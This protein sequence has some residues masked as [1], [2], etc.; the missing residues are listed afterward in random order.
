MPYMV[1]ICVDYIVLRAAKLIRKSPDV[2]VVKYQSPPASRGKETKKLWPLITKIVLELIILVISEL[3][4]D[5]YH[6]GLVKFNL[7]RHAGY[8]KLSQ[9]AFIVSNLLV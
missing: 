2:I 6:E 4:S 7:L 5:S 1:E 9:I 3:N 8:E